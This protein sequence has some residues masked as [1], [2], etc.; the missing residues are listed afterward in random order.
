MN[1][2]LGGLTPAEFLERHWQKEP[3]LV[4]GAVK[5]FDD[6]P[7]PGELAALACEEG[8]TS[9]LIHMPDAEQGWS[10]DHGPFDV[11]TLSSLPVAGWT[12]LVQE[13]DR[14]LDSVA[15]LL[16]RFRFIPNWRIDDVMVSYAR[17]GAGVG[18]HVDRYDVF[19]IQAAGRRR[20]RIG[21]G[22]VEHEQLVPGIEVRVLAEFA[23][24]QEWILEPGDMLYLP[25]RIAHEGVAIGEST[26]CSVGFRAPDPLDL[27]GGFFDALARGEA[28]QTLYADPELAPAQSSGEISAAARQ[29]LRRAVRS[30]ID[31]DRGF[32][33]FLGRF[34]TDPGP[35]SPLAA[36]F[37]DP[38]R[39]SDGSTEPA[40]LAALETAVDRAGKLHRSAVPHL[41]WF[42]E[43][44]RVLLFAAGVAY[45]MGPQGEAL[46]E[47]ICGRRTLDRETLAPGLQDRRHR[48]VLAELFARGVLIPG[49]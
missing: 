8:V 45:D 46:A 4:R 27:G 17:D 18:A 42:R 29:G 37:E 10:V 1:E 32:D 23:P 48:A 22:P 49:D 28:L 19:L 5:D 41:A 39:V 31:R 6:A 43:D 11:E 38:D 33:R 7:Q 36:T 2:L 14:Y 44:D 16:D 40:D 30:M 9:R 26:T 20:W 12:L 24:A 34:L 25:P 15:D 47:T 35:G 3:L 21:D 13:V